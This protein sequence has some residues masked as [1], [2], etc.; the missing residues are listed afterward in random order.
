M[1]DGLTQIK[2]IGHLLVLAIGVWA[3]ATFSLRVVDTVFFDQP[4][5]RAQQIGQ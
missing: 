5:F 3:V 2:E 4:L 1:S